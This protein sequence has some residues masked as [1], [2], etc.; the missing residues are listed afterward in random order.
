MTISAKKAQLANALQVDNGII[1]L[2]LAALPHII[3]AIF[4]PRPTHDIKAQIADIAGSNFDDAIK[5]RLTL[6]LI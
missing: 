1:E 2:I 4:R 3:D 5:W 6:Q